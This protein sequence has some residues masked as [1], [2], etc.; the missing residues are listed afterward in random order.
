MTQTEVIASAMS[1]LSKA[2]TERTR[3]DAKAAAMAREQ[4]EAIRFALVA[5][6]APKEIL[7]V[8]KLSRARLYQIRDGR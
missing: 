2:T 5:G 6:I 1:R 7:R 4:A 8:T 3:A